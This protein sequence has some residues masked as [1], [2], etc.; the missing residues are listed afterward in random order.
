MHTPVFLEKVLSHIQIPQDT[1]YIDCTLG[2][3]GHT[4]A[5][6]Q[7]G[8]TVLAI[9]ADRSQIEAFRQGELSETEQSRISVV[10]GNFADVASIAKSNGFEHCDGILFD[11]GLS[12]RQLAQGEGFSFKYLHQPLDMIVNTVAKQGGATRAADVV[13]KY[14]Y[15]DLKATFEQYGER[16]HAGEIAGAIVEARAK[17]KIETVGDL[18]QALGTV[19]SPHNY[20]AIFQA[21]RVEVNQEFDNLRKGLE[22]ALSI[23]RPGGTFQIITFH[24]GE[25]RIVKLWGR[26]NN[27][28]ELAKYVGRAVSK[29]TFEKSAVLRVYRSR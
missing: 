15:D 6:A 17:K 27:L 21:I 1:R 24:S 5:L 20:P 12:M 18:V 14:S 7:K 29:E 28:E 26:K 19:V 8:L 25:D 9:E 10:E 22:G 2:E 3:G 16:I 13:T 4:R 23:V 11:L